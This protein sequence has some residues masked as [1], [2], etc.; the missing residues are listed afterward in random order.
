ML[1]GRSVEQAEIFIFSILPTPPNE[2]YHLNTPNE[3]YCNPPPYLWPPSFPI[4]LLHLIFK[5]SESDK[6]ILRYPAVSDL[7]LLM[8]LTQNV[9]KWSRDWW[10]NFRRSIWSTDSPKTMSL[11]NKAKLPDCFAV[12]LSFT[13][14][15]HV[16]SNQIKSFIL[17][18][19]IPCNLREF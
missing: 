18:F 12:S 1:E 5:Q 7:W 19:C 16:D 2:I 3:I 13:T 8:S 14:N 17:S 10:K 6:P 9:E 15:I 11:H 4:E